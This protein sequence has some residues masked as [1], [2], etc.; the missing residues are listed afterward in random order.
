MGL[1]GIRCAPEFVPK[2]GPQIERARGQHSPLEVS[3]VDS[4]SSRS[5]SCA[6][7]RCGSAGVVM[8]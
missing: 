1:Y 7:H 8:V 5:L 3:P 4:W 2:V 6:R